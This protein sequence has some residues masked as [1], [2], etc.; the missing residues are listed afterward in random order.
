[1]Q[2]GIL[3]RDG[4]RVFIDRKGFKEWNLHVYGSNGVRRMMIQMY[5]ALKQEL[6]GWF[7]E[8][9]V[10][11]LLLEWWDKRRVIASILIHLGS[12]NLGTK[13]RKLIS[14]MG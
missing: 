3:M 11:V 2:Q 5:V 10:V 12:N 4:E 1:M 6:E 9:G 14:Y 7:E 8:V 13:L